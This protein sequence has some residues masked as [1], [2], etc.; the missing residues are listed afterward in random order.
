MGLPNTDAPRNAIFPFWDD[1]NPINEANSTN[2]DGYVRYH[3]SDE[4]IVIWYD[5]VR[6]WTGGSDMD[7]Y[8]DFQVVLYPD[9]IIDFNYR[10]MTGDTD[11]ATIGIQNESGNSGVNITI[12]QTF[13]EDMKTVKIKGRP[14][15]LTVSPLNLILEP[16]ATDQI[17]LSFNTTSIPAGG[18]N[19]ILNLKTNDF[20][21]SYIEIPVMLN[22]DGTPC[23]GAQLGDLNSDSLWNILDIILIVNIILYDTEDEC[24]FYISDMN[25]DENINVLDIVLVINLILDD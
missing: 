17:N 1:L 9:G 21:F 25:G 16:G 12:N 6:R 19:Y 14:N 18:Y 10:S 22:V 5:N 4:R 11:S 7:G 24:E 23:G 13:V 15:W 8:F 20:H 2:M 3:V